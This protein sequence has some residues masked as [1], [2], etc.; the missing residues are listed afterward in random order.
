M[1]RAFLFS[2]VIVVTAALAMPQGALAH[3]GLIA[4]DPVDGA[5]LPSAPAKMTLTFTE[6]V[7]PLVFTL[8]NSGG[9]RQDLAP[10]T[11]SND[12]VVVAL[13]TGLEAGTH[14]LSWRV[15]SA[16]G[17]PVAGTLAFSIGAP[18]IRPK[19][20]VSADPLR[21][22][23]IW[24]V[25]AVIYVALFVSVGGAVFGLLV[26]PLP[27]LLS[28][29]LGQL[30]LAAL[31]LTLLA[32]G[33]QGLDALN[34][35]FARLV[36]PDPWRAALGTSYASTAAALLLAFS[37][38]ALACRVGGARRRGLV[39]LAWGAA[40]LAPML[41]GHAGT[42]PPV[43]LSRPAVVLHIASLV[44]WL[45]ALWP[46]AHL[47]RRPNEAASQAALRRFSRLIPVPLLVLVVS[48]LGLGVLQMGPPDPSWSSPYAALFA[49]KLFVVV[50]LL[51]VAFWNRAR[52]TVP[53]LGGEA[54]AAG[55]LRRS[56]RVE[57]LLVGLILLLVAGWRF[58]PPPR[59]LAEVAAQPA[60]VHIH[61]ADAM[62]DV[63]LTPGHAGPAV[64]A[65][66]LMD[67]A[68]APLTPRAVTVQFSN[69]ALGVERLSRPAQ[70]EA[71]GYWRVPVTLPAGGAWTIGIALRI[72]DFTE[73][74]LE[75]D[76]ELAP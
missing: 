67:G 53:A 4:A 20:D 69:T 48:G 66:Y 29:R 10:P 6:P 8:V 74:R 50:L 33:L 62:A 37:A 21:I 42:A 63:T 44:F 54:A 11:A 30:S 52:L 2:L 76:L 65:L 38:T 24:A 26:A 40:S 51:G 71:D 19:L 59:V 31:P 28:R 22:T 27:P 61:T 16:D 41:S 34:M 36:T 64:L 1:L 12:V 75:G 25:R 17:H 3:A 32:L 7:T 60:H 15:V 9:D 13:P 58:T 35:G 14:L 70:L 57:L 72:D 46:L 56:I 47:M 5:V 43:W 45:G 23:L 73:V 39:I 55:A 49:G 18:G 68:M